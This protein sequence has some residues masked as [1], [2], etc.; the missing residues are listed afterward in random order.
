MTENRHNNF[1]LLL[2][3]LARRR[4]FI[5]TLT[6]LATLVAVAM[7]VVLPDWYKAEALIMPPKEDKAPMINL[8]GLSE[9]AAGFDLATISTSADVFVQILKSRTITDRVIDKFG[10]MERYDAENYVEA[11]E[12]L[13]D[14]AEIVKT[15]EGLLYV[16]VS[17]MDAKMA[18]DLANAFVDE[19]DRASREVIAAQAREKR[20][21]FNE[22]LNQV[23]EQLASARKDLERFQL[24]YKTVDFDEQTRLAIEQAIR[25]KVTL[26][27]IDI[28]IRMLEQN[29][30]SD[31][32]ELV[33][34]RNH[35]NIV[36]AELQELETGN[37]DSS[38][39]S[40][41]LASIPVLKSEYESYYSRVRVNEALSSML[42]QQLEQARIQEGGSFT[43]FS[44]LQRAVPP[45]I[46]YRPQRT[47]IVLLTFVLSLIISILLAS[48]L[49]YFRK[50]QA[51][52]PDDYD[53][54]LM[55]FRAYLGWLPGIK[56][57][58]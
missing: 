20:V 8:G 50:L 52:S 41:P 1:W 3:V 4:G 26:A 6:I 48:V 42:M 56:R 57:K 46:S 55:F 13:M 39:F 14:N 47:L 53:R 11:F 58:G 22:R 25:L 35:R 37:S 12:T 16:A 18:A 33:D 43:E 32:A 24:Q 45:E 23:N 49:E 5:L 30:R 36:K 19:L 31:N 9:G 28:Q 34:L 27:E 54:A 21:F 40:L 38:F 10:L 17:D 15:T 51:K 44:V 2:E 7:A 29:L